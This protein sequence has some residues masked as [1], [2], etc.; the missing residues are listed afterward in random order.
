MCKYHIKY[1]LLKCK[2]TFFARAAVIHL[3]YS[4]KATVTTHLTPTVLFSSQNNPLVFAG[5]I[6]FN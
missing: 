3:S 2:N 1:K 6:V 4:G 5:N